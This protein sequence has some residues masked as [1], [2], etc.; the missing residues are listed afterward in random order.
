MYTID[1]RRIVQQFVQG[2]KMTLRINDLL[3]GIYLIKVIDKGGNAG[4]RRIVVDN[5]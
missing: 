5:N 2:D 4:W 1:G 3:D